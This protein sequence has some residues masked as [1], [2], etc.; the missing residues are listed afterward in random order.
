[1][2]SLHE[3][4]CGDQQQEPEVRDGQPGLRPG[5]QV[6]RLGRGRGIGRGARAI[7]RAR[8]KRMNAKRSRQNFLRKKDKDHK[9]QTFK[10]QA[11]ASN[12]SGRHRTMDHLL[13]LQPTD[14]AR[15]KPKG[16][17]AWKKWTPEA[18]L[19]AAFGQATASVR[20]SAREVDGASPSH[21]IKAR[22]FIA[23]CILDCQKNIFHPREIGKDKGRCF[24]K[25]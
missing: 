9:R 7:F 15:P 20:Q 19:R 14:D 10:L 11:M 4:A 24:I 2:L 18:M 8:A 13:P 21:V 23:S 5:A 16:R 3:I 17:G 25:F 1:M 6:G 22:A 12:A